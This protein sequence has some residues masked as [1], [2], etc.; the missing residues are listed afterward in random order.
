MIYFFA[1]F[2][3][4][5]GGEGLKA[6]Q[7][8]LQSAGR[9]SNPFEPRDLPSDR[10]AHSAT[11]QPAHRLLTIIVFFQHCEHLFPDPGTRGSS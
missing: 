10:Q 4:F 8:N 2:I 11:L 9:G 3:I 1:C 7:N 6:Q 5:G